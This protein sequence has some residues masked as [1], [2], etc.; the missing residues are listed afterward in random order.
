MLR[1]KIK[2]DS[3]QLH[4]TVIINQL[5]SNLDTKTHYVNIHL[6]FLQYSVGF[7]CTSWK[8]CIWWW[9][10]GMLKS[11][12]NLHNLYIYLYK[13]D[14][15][16]CESINIFYFFFFFQE[17]FLLFSISLFCHTL[18]N[19]R[20]ILKQKNIGIRCKWVQRNNS[21]EISFTSPIYKEN[22]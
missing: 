19:R 18:I 21:S 5:H 2:K 20:G 1:E 12:T 10:G 9:T 15:R 4:L 8:S 3:P 7:F 22:V 17:H 11:G 6:I 13:Y 16:Y 14:C